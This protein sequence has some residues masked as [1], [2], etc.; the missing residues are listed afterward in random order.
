MQLQWAHAVVYVQ[1]MQ[2]M[3]DFYTNI[4]GFE[5]ADRGLVNGEGT[6]EIVFLSQVATDHHQIAF[7][8]IRKEVTPSNSVN[9]FA[10]RVADLGDVKS[11]IDTLEKDGRATA[12]NPMSHGNAWS[13]YFQDPEQNGVEVFCDTPFHVAQPQGKTWDPTSSDA[14]ILAWTTENFKDQPGFGPIE[15]YYELRR[16]ELSERDT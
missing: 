2:A 7:L 11:M 1:D 9:H 16:A 4:L 8:Q 15:D 13:I 10:F 5:I 12:M 14:E 6:P 3:L